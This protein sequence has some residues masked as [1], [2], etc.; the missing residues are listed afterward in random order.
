MLLYSLILEK[1]SFIKPTSEIAWRIFFSSLSFQTLRPKA[2]TRPE[3]S[4]VP[5]KPKH[6]A[7]DTVKMHD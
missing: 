4:F 7:P 2:L 5:T 6:C 3:G 1:K